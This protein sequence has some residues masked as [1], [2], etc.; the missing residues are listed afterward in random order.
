MLISSKAPSRSRRAAAPPLRARFY[1]LKR[2]AARIL[3]NPVA[4]RLISAAFR[5]QV[6]S[7]GVRVD[8]S[9]PSVL[10]STKAAL[11]W[12][13]YESAEARF[14]QSYLRRDLDVVELGSS[15]GVISAQ[16]ARRLGPSGTLICV[17]ANPHL[18]GV[19]EKNVRRNCALAR[20]RIVHGALSYDR[21]EKR[22]HVAFAIDAD[23]TASSLAGGGVG[24]EVVQVPA[25]TLGELLNEHGVGEYTLV[26]DVEGAEI[27]FIENDGELSRCRQLIIELHE[28][29]W[30]G[31]HFTVEEMRETLE[32]RH[33]FR[34]RARHG[35]VFVFEK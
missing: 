23:N 3:C 7:R 14:V 12:G 2:I 10:P 21:G 19:I 8:T 32:R 29:D 13:I 18:I 24:G 6:P 11:F 33:G 16:I 30:G 1:T 25:L 27:G 20:N 4:G 28:A 5:D 22:S 26:S 15:L 17:E 34:T 9:S 31:R 35:P